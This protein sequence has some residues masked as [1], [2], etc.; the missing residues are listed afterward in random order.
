MVSQRLSFRIGPAADDGAGPAPP[1][2][3]GLEPDDGAP[4]DAW[5]LP[6]LPPPEKSSGHWTVTLENPGSR[7]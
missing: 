5:P 6:L 4:Y 3:R 1:L 7:L 2:H